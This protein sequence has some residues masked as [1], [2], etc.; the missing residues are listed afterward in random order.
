VR[1]GVSELLLHKE[2]VEAIGCKLGGEWCPAATAMVPWPLLYRRGK[3][4]AGQVEGEGRGG[5][6]K[7]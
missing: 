4:M 3:V 5:A 1:Q 2:P 7:C 6:V